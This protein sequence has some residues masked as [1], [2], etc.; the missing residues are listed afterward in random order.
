MR[1]RLVQQ[2]GV[3]TG[4]TRCPPPDCRSHRRQSVTEPNARTAPDP[5]RPPAPP[6]VTTVRPAAAASSSAAASSRVLP[7]PGP[8]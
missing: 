5:R 1:V 2:M 6:T 8:P 4:T 3:V 7:A